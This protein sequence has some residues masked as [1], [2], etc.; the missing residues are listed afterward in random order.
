MVEFFCLVWLN[1][2]ASLGGIWSNGCG[3]LL[4]GG[5]ERGET[6]VIGGACLNGWIKKCEDRL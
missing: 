5:L 2:G 6:I 3:V 4:M 1:L